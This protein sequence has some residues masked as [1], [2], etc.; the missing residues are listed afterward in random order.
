MAP[1]IRDATDSNGPGSA[2]HHFVLRCARD[3]R[4]RRNTFTIARVGGPAKPGLWLFPVFVL[5]RPVI[6]GQIGRALRRRPCR[7]PVCTPPLTGKG[8]ALGCS[9]PPVF[10]LLFT[11]KYRAAGPR[12]SPLR[13]ADA[14]VHHYLYA[15]SAELA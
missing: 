14:A 9:W 13:V 15:V 5:F 4:T 1:L 7:F 6:D 2:A 12:A 10:L 3:T 8:A 11:G